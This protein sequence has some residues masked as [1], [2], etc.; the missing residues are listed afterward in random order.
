MSRRLKETWDKVAYSENMKYILYIISFCFLGVLAFGHGHHDIPEDD[1]ELSRIINETALYAKNKYNL[2]LMGTGISCP[3]GVFMSQG[4]SFGINHQFTKEECREILLDLA[5]RHKNSTNASK[6]LVQIMEK[7]PFT[8]KNVEIN[9]F[10]T[11]ADGEDTVDPEWAV[12]SLSYGKYQF[13]TNDPDNN[14]RYKIDI[15]EV[16]FEQ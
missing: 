1:A 3:G 4:L 12:V 16:C 8:L 6:V 7:A 10:F 5:T 2:D 9:I 15:E 14:F 13:R 11:K